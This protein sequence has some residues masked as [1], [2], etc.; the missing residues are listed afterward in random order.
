[1]VSLEV[2]GPVWKF[3]VTI[4]RLTDPPFD[5]KVDLKPKVE[6]KEESILKNV[7]VAMF[8]ER[9]AKRWGKRGL[10]SFWI[11]CALIVSEEMSRSNRLSFSQYC[12]AIC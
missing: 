1:M 5:P 4:V 11:C 8:H 9:R 3:L 10:A 2:G 12:D 7:E 6:L